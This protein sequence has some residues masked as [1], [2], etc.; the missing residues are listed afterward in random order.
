MRAGHVPV[1]GA[2][3]IPG[4]LAVDEDG[5]A[6]LD[7][8]GAVAVGR[9]QP[10]GGGEDEG[11]FL[12]REIFGLIVFQRRRRG[13]LCLRGHGDAGQGHRGGR[14]F[15]KAAAAGETGG[16]GHRVAPA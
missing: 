4:Q 15:Q 8:A 5:H 10:G 3:V 16:L 12:G 6:G 13:E 9:D 2:A 11:A 7:R 14:G 1:L